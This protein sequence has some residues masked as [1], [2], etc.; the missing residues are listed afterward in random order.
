MSYSSKEQK[1]KFKKI[2]KVIKIDK[3]FHSEKYYFDN[4]KVEETI[5]I[6]K[7]NIEYSIMKVNT[8]RMS[9]EYL[10]YVLIK[11]P[12]N[13]VTHQ[14]L[15]QCIGITKTDK[16]FNKLKRYI[17]KNTN[18]DI[19]NRCYQDLANFPRKN[20]LIKLLGI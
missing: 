15:E 10:V 8:D 4:G 9:D 11:T 5:D 16:C 20:F 18:E 13:Y 12:D 7:D 1:K 14:L 17:E 2:S 19:I 6:T 3:I